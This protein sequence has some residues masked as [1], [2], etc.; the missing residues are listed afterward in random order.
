[1]KKFIRLF[2]LLLALPG[3]LL[4]TGCSTSGS[5]SGSVSV[6]YGIYGGYGYP[7][8]GYRYNDI[9]INR[10]DRPDRPNR[11]ERPGLKP[12][13]DRPSTQPVSR[14]R[15]SGGM[16]RPAGMSRGRR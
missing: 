11:P 12:K 3:A 16:G 5:G 8:Y 6:H 14:P 13:P 1:M 10:P 9:N 2:V 7:R 4:L 15:S